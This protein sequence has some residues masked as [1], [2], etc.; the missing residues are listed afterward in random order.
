[1]EPFLH[2]GGQEGG[3]RSGAHN[4]EG[5]AGFGKAAGI[6]EVGDI[7]RVAEPKD[8][9]IQKM[10]TLLTKWILNGPRVKRLCNDINLRCRSVNGQS[11]AEELMRRIYI[12]AGAACLSTKVAPSYVL[13]AIGR[14]FKQAQEAIRI[15]LSRWTIMEEM[16]IVVQS[17]A[18]IVQRNREIG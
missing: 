6:V 2:G 7:K 4:T 3:L 12:S 13:L 5:I 15:S 11:L 1:M 9:F 16:D 18:E 14:K 17:L 8:H 10:Q